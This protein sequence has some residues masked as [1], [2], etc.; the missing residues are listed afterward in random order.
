M[1]RVAQRSQRP[2]ASA[3]VPT[4]RLQTLALSAYHLE[5]LQFFCILLK[6][7]LKMEVTVR[8]IALG[9]LAIFVPRPP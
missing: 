5:V 3:G 2:T 6:S 9:E 4:T 7:K 1:D 8:R